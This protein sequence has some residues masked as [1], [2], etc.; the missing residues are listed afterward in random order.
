[1]TNTTQP[2]LPHYV[3]PNEGWSCWVHHDQPIEYCTNFARR[4]AY[5]RTTKPAHEQAVRLA[6][7][8]C[9]PLDRLP[10][11]LIQACNA[12]NQARTAYDQAWNAYDQAG[13]E[14][15]QACNAYNQARTAYDQAGNEYAQ[16]FNA[17]NQARTSYIQAR[18]VYAQAWTA[19]EQARTAY[20]PILLTLMAELVPA[21]LWR[22]DHLVFPHPT[23]EAQ[24]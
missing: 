15:S 12:Y 14:Y 18:A 2:G 3:G 8:T 19:Y 24:P 23:K 11:T 1:M 13:T 16:V 10:P 4:I 20:N 7:L 9:L 21:H 17:Y 22:D 5:I 6:A